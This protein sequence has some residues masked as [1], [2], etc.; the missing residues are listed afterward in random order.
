MAES[1]T[2]VQDDPASEVITDFKSQIYELC[3]HEPDRIY[4]QDDL[5]SMDIIPNND[6]N[7][8]MAVVQGLVDEKLFKLVTMDGGAAY[9]YR[10]QK[11]AKK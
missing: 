11:E 10:S 4:N 9:M 2:P 6:V 8:L 5:F 7:V 3:G 1:K